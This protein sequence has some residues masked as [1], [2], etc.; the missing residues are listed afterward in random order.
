MLK[1]EGHLPVLGSGSHFFCSGKNKQLS[2]GPVFGVLAVGTS[3]AAAAFFTEEVLF[4]SFGAGV[5]GG[6]RGSVGFAIQSNFGGVDFGGH[7]GS[8]GVLLQ[9]SCVV[10]GGGGGGGGGGFASAEEE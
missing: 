2:S 5:G 4:S 9:S 10:G 1:P 7:A 6:Q 8:L 3:D